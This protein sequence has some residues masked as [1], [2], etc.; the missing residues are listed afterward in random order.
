MKHIV[1]SS[2]VARRWPAINHF[3]DRNIGTI[4]KRSYRALFYRKREAKKKKKEEER[5]NGASKREINR[6]IRGYQ[7]CEMTGC[8]VTDISP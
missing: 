3:A 7:D 8:R 5:I 6:A 1:K 2:V 4:E